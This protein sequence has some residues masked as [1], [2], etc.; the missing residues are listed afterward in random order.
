[1]YIKYTQILALQM[2][3]QNF[4]TNNVFWTKKSKHKTTTQNKRAQRALGRSPEST[5]NAVHQILV[6]DL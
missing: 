5:T 1:M 2:E 6:E 4:M 3:L